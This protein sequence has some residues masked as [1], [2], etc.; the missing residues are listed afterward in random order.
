VLGDEN[1]PGLLQNNGWQRLPGGMIMQWGGV[2]LDGVVNFPIPFD[3]AC[4]NIQ[5]T[6][7]TTNNGRGR[8]EGLWTRFSFTKGSAEVGNTA[9]FWQAI[10][11]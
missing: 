2:I 9:C 6:P 7:N 11:Y 1:Y 10:G 5:L 4:L 8:V 3:N